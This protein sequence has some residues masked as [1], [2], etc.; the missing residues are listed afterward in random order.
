ME[1]QVENTIHFPYE[2]KPMRSAYYTKNQKEPDFTNCSQVNQD[3]LFHVTIDY[4]FLSPHWDVL[5]VYV[6]SCYYEDIQP[7][8]I[9]TQGSDHVMLGVELL[10]K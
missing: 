9:E 7:Y 10:C 2:C 4:I 6:L 1:I 5:S 8:P 3:P